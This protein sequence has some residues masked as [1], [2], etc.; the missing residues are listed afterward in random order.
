MH[1]YRWLGSVWWCLT[2][3]RYFEDG[4]CCPVQP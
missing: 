3:N 1:D 4:D 2:H